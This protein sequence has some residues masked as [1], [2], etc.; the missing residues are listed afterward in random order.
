LVEIAVCDAHPEMVAQ[1]SAATQ[2]VS[3]DIDLN[4]PAGARRDYPCY[5]S[6]L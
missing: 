4:F 2:V 5:V 1:T 6:G 3:Y